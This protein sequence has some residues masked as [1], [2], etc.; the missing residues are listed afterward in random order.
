M[1]ARRDQRASDRQPGTPTLPRD[2]SIR[3]C[4]KLRASLCTA[5][6]IQ[7]RPGRHLAVAL[8]DRARQQ[9]TEVIDSHPV[10]RARRCVS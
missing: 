8:A 10:I 5:L 1:Y 7:G 4:P 3:T 2:Q 6:P 9:I